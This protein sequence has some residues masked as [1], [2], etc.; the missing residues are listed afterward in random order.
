VSDKTRVR[1]Y[2]VFLA[3]LTVAGAVFLA[4]YLRFG[5]GIPCVFYAVTGL[6]CPGCGSTRSVLALLRFDFKSAF[7]Y[8][9]LFV[10]LIPWLAFLFAVYSKDYIL[11]GRFQTRRYVDISCYIFAAFLL[12]FSVVRN[13]RVLL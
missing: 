9:P 1:R 8:N 4:L 13:L 10:L 11:L 12:I 6:Q 7:I 3:A 2:L 5:R